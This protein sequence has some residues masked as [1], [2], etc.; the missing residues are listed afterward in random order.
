MCSLKFHWLC[1]DAASCEIGLRGPPHRA[2]LRPPE[3][4]R[5]DALEER[6]CIGLELLQRGSRAV[7]RAMQSG[8]WQQR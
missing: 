5:K 1:A 2:V 3:A 7:V 8:A 6:V 4:V